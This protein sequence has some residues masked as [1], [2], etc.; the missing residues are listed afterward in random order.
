MTLDWSTVTHSRGKATLRVARRSRTC[1]KGHWTAAGKL[2]PYPPGLLS[3]F[4]GAGSVRR[5][6][7]ADGTS[8]TDLQ[9]LRV[10]KGWKHPLL[11]GLSRG[12]RSDHCLQSTFQVVRGHSADGLFEL[13]NP[14]ISPAF[15]MGIGQSVLALQCPSSSP[16]ERK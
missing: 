10:L 15:G 1:L 13:P 5:V 3:T 7:A 4:L 9:C 2:S 16:I 12:V 8:P 14:A 6:P 11:P